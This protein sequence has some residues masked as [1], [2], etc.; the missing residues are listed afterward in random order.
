MRNK[1]RSRAFDMM[2]HPIRVDPSVFDYFASKFE[3]VQYKVGA[4]R[5]GDSSVLLVGRKKE[6]SPTPW[7]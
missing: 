3:K 2:A 1:I 5:R 7:H 4:G 6:A